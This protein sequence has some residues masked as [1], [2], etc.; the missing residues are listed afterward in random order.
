MNIHDIV[1]IR[2]ALEY[3]MRDDCLFTIS[4]NTSEIFTLLRW[5]E[6]YATMLRWDS[7]K[8]SAHTVPRGEVRGVLLR[9]L[10]TETVTE[11]KIRCDVTRN[12]RYVYPYDR[13]YFYV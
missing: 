3:F 1:N 9:I 12:V 13:R 8:H 7:G 6:P 4:T 5:D 11:V 2:G 10:Y